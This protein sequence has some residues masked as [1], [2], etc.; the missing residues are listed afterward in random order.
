MGRIDP[1]I[2]Q[3]PWDG[4]SVADQSQEHHKYIGDPDY[5]PY[6]KRRLSYA[7]TFTNPWKSTSIRAIELA[8]GK[9]RLLHL[10]RQFES[11]GPARGQEFWDRTLDVMGIDLQTPAEQIARIPKTGPVVVVA[12]HPHGLVDGLVMGCLVGRVRQDFKILTRS[13]LTGI[14]EIAYH[15][16]PVPFPHE[17]DAQRKGLEMRRHA[18]DHLKNDGVVILF[19]SGQVAASETWFGPAVEAD[20]NPFTAKMVLRSGATVLPIYF[21]GQNSRAYQIANKLSPTL[22]QGLLLHEIKYA[23]NR[24][25]APVIGAPIAPEALQEWSSNPRGFMAWMR[26]QTLALGSN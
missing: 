7:G 14:E 8:T 26:E 9:L 4:S 3:A 18:M 6:D 23:L 24:P 16:V 19:P 5:T 17:E 2:E 25:Q 13:L 15:M 22:R 11:R 10:I 20:W 12:N 1:G 21:P